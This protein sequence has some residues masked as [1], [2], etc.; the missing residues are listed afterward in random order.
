M[1]VMWCVCSG[2]DESHFVDVEWFGRLKDA[3]EFAETLPLTPSGKPRPYKIERH[4]FEGD[5]K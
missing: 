2:P 1:K 5:Y 4:E 3:K